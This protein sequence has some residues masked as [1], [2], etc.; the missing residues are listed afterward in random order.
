MLFAWMVTRSDEKRQF[1]VGGR[2]VIRMMSVFVKCGERSSGE[3][4]TKQEKM[5]PE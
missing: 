5:F 3:G 2:T 4:D 1:V